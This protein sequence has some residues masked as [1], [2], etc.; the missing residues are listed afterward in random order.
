M[1][2]YRNLDWDTATD[3]PIDPIVV[4]NWYTALE[5]TRNVK[6]FYLIVE[7][8]NNGAAA[9]NI[10]AELTID[11]TAYVC[12]IGGAASGTPYYVFADI[13]GALDQVGN[14]RQILS[15][16]LDQSAP[17]ETRSLQVRV[18][19]TSA[20]DVVSAIIEVNMVYATLERV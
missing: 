11:G 4:N 3:V 7:Q 2:E 12:G 5:T 19:Q 10:E 18:R 1:W 8:T 6:A 9:E 14:V 15:L 17:L 20:V 13:D 16:D